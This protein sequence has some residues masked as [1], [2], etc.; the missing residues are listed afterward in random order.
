MR[1]RRGL[2][3]DVPERLGTVVPARDIPASAGGLRVDIDVLIARY[4]APPLRTVDQ[5][6]YGAGEVL[7]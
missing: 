3:L 2:R 6:F 5:M 1:L 7:V 4:W